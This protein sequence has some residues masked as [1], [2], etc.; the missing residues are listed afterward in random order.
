MDYEKG[1]IYCIRNYINKD[2][3]VGSSCQPL[4][5]RLSWHKSSMNKKC[6]AKY[7]L[8]DKMR[9]LGKENFYIELLENYP[10]SNKEELRAREG[11]YIRQMGN[12]NKRIENRTKKQWA[13][14]NAES[15]K[16]SKDKYY[17]NKKEL[18]KE[19]AKKH[20]EEH[21]EAKIE[22]QKQYSEENKEKIKETRQI[23]RMNNREKIMKQAYERLTCDCGTV[24][25]RQNKLRHERSKKHQEYLKSLEQD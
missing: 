22:Y 11:H 7:P 14:D 20:Y 12:L 1:K 2:I 6:C 19:R 15:V 24:F 5:K 4:C 17:E 9:E 21:R 23:Y 8:Y 10:C 25:M 3:Y 16:A 13:E 18:V